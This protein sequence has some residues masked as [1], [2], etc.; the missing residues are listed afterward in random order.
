MERI[1]D[2][3]LDF[4]DVST[5]SFFLYFIGYFVFGYFNVFLV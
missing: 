2:L 3:N 1:Q 5:E 4:F